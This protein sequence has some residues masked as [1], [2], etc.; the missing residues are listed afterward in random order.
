MRCRPTVGF[1]R[2]EHH[3]PAAFEAGDFG[4]MGKRRAVG[5]TIASM[6]LFGSLLIS[7]FVLVSA[8]QER[9][10]LFSVADQEDALYDQGLAIKS[11]A[12]VD[13]LDGVQIGLSSATLPCS[14]TFSALSS[15]VGS[16]SVSIDDSYGVAEASA[17]LAS[18]G[19]ASDNL[20]AL[21]PFLGSIPG[22]LDL[23]AAVKVHLESRGGV[24]TY[25]KSET[26][27]LN[28]PIGLERVVSFCQGSVAEVA[29]VLDALG[30]NLCNATAVRSALTSLQLELAERATGLG[31]TTELWFSIAVPPYCGVDYSVH[32]SEAGV[33]GPLGPFTWSVEEAQ[34][35]YQ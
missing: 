20:T 27:Y 23:L 1:N 15:L 34:S 19:S 3:S 32:V 11:V 2:I 33:P 6:L 4:G 26:H 22:H 16:L 13:L 17:R 9:M 8:Q 10:Q 24:A 28:L 7:N 25:S 14:T 35:F 21:K 5:A 18:V 30:S 12:L 29:R 31:L